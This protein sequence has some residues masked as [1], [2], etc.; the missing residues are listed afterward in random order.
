MEVIKVNTQKPY[1]IIIDNNLLSRTN[2]FVKKITKAQKCAIISDDNVAPLYLDV[3]KKSLEKDFK[4][5]SFVFENGE[6]SKSQKTLNEIYDFLF[7]NNFTRSDIVIALGGGVVGDISGFASATFLRGIKYVQI[8]TTLLAQIDSSIGGKCAINCS[9]GKNLIGA[10]HQPSLVLCDPTVLLT[11]D[12]NDF[13]SGACEAIKYS[14]IRDEKII[15]LIDED[16]HKNI[17]EI[18]KR[19]INI[20]REIVENDELDLGERM[21]LNFGH[22]LAHSIEKKSNFKI[23]HGIAVGIGMSRILKAFEKDE[24]MIKRLDSVLLKIGAENDCDF[25]NSELFDGIL[26]DKKRTGNFINIVLCDKIGDSYYKKYS[27]NELKE[28]LNG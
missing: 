20:K 12:D 22:T 16:I 23:P 25:S 13:V 3:V 8:P 17:I 5:C 21:L 2:E 27:T 15:D 26:N 4:V 24:K 28:I 14:M 18:I 7:E 10:F 9:F 11:L 6:K 19:C 1:E